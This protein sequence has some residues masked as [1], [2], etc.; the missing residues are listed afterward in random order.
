[1]R[2]P[3]DHARLLTGGRFCRSMVKIRSISRPWNSVS[4]VIAEGG[5]PSCCAASRCR[6]SNQASVSSGPSWRRSCRISHLT[7][8]SGFFFRLAGRRSS[9]RRG[10]GS[11]GS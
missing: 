3:G 4:R 8:S 5:T 2:E 10:E 7:C 9:S 1:M 11:R 6:D